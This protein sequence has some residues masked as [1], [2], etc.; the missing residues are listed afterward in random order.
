MSDSEKEALAEFVFTGTILDREYLFN[1]EVG[2][3]YTLCLTAVDGILKNTLP[4]LVQ[5][6]ERG[7]RWGNLT[8]QV[9]PSLQVN[10]GDTGM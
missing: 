2:H 7:G 10:T 8:E 1:Q 4:Q 9:K 5:I 6:A 3:I